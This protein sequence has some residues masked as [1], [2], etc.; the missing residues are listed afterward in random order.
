MDFGDRVL[1][2]AIAFVITT[3]AIYLAIRYYETVHSNGILI[4]ILIPLAIMLLPGP[5]YILWVSRIKPYVPGND[6]ILKKTLTDRN[7]P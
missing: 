2:M 7:K 6:D 1:H 3:I 4:G 5:C